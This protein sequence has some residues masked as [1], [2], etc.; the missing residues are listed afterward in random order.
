MEQEEYRVGSVGIHPAAAVMNGFYT[1][2]G[3]SNNYSLDYKHEF[4]EIIAY[5]LSQN[6]YNMI[7][8]DHW[9]SRCYLF[10]SDYNGC[11]MLEKEKHAVF[12]D[13]QIDGRKMKEMGCYY[14]ISAG[15][16]AEPELTGL[17]LYRTFERDDSYY[18]IYLYKVVGGEYTT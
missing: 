3:Y 2:D 16:I 11:A 13:F 6:E 9:G 1:I 15:E 18:R 8:F 17:A 14:L 10:A 7:Y 5:E 12:H 4:R